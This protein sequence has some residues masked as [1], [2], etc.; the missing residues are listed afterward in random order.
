MIE[1][2]T[3]YVY[4]HLF[5]DIPIPFIIIITITNPIIVTK[6]VIIS[7]IITQEPLSM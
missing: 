2:G 1:M 3:L 5:Y 4:T 7:I 6:S